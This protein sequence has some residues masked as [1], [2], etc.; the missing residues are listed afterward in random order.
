MEKWMNAKVLQRPHL[1]AMVRIAWRIGPLVAR[2]QSLGTAR[3]G[4]GPT[5]LGN[6]DG[7]TLPF[8]VIML[9]VSV[10][11]V[12]SVMFLATHFRSITSAEDGERSYYALDA[13]VEAVM[14]DLVRGAD[15]LDS[16]NPPAVTINGLTPSVTIA[17]PGS[18]ASPT[19]LQQYFDPGLRHPHLATIPEGKRYLVH[20]FNVH[21]GVFQA[22]WAFNIAATGTEAPAGTVSL[23]VLKNPDVLLTPPGRFSGCPTSPL[24][25]LVEKSID[26]AGTFSISSGGITVGTPEPGEPQPGTYS[27]AFCVKTLTGATLTTRPY[28]PTGSLNDTW[29]YAIA[30]KDYRITAE[31]EGASITVDVRQMPGPTQPPAGNWSDTNI[32]WITNRVT[33]Y[34]WAR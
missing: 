24:V 34:Q 14:A 27:V 10:V 6:Q 17:T 25:A 20:V 22:N 4:Q 18:A 28:K 15:L 16:Y 7:F 1:A 33:P 32:S 3:L 21:P 13:A 29:I 12:S 23:R 5:C 31:A 19:P 11:A 9:A 2:R 30:F 26:S 8:V